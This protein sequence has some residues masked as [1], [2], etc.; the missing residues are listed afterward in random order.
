M[1]EKETPAQKRARVRAAIIDEDPGKRRVRHLAYELGVSMTLLRSERRRYALELLRR[2]PNMSDST[3]EYRTGVTAEDLL[4]VHWAYDSGED[5]PAFCSYQ[6]RKNRESG[7]YG[8][9]G[10]RKRKKRPE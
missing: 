10:Q 8:A 3:L 9:G 1:S 4:A 5:V 7:T 6:D 2:H